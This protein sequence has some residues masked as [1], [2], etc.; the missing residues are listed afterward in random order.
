MDTSAVSSDFKLGKTF[1]IFWISGTALKP[2]IW[3]TFKY[4]FE[5]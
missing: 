1:V 5:I 3:K 4:V 2:V